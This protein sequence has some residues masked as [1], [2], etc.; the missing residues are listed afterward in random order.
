[1]AGGMRGGG[2]C[3][4][5]G[6]HGGGRVQ[7]GVRGRTEGHC[8]GRYASYCNAFLSRILLRLAT[9]RVSEIQ[10]SISEI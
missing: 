4:V 10:L 6:V 1:M 8:S 3:K 7:W 9:V 5:G 2:V